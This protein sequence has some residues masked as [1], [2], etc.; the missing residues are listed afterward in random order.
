MSKLLMSV[1][2]PNGH[3][4][5]ELLAQTRQELQ[6]KTDKL[7]GSDC[8]ASGIIRRNNSYIASL[9]DVAERIQRD[10]MNVL[11]TV[12]EDQG[13]TGTPRV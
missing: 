9:L 2:N 11:D 12:G 6:E 3:K 10:T 5:E 13:P 4:L 8:P 7:D 1:D